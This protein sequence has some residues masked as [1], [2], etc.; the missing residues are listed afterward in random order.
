[1]EFKQLIER[2]LSRWPDEEMAQR[3]YA[4]T[5]DF[6]PQDIVDTIKE[7]TLNNALIRSTIKNS[8][9]NIPIEDVLTVVATAVE[10]KYNSLFQDIVS[11][12]RQIS[13][14]QEVVKLLVAE[15]QGD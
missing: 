9:E 8:L 14:F 13:R 6:S 10:A 1:M 5:I 15:I 7:T 12:E 3:Y 2:S 4:E 11:D